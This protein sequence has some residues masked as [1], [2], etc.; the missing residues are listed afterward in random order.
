[1]LQNSTE[2]TIEDFTNPGDVHMEGARS[3]AVRF[4]G[5]GESSPPPAPHASSATTE[6][7]RKV[8]ASLA[9]SG[10][11]DLILLAS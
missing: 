1:M 8:G 7:T 6:S 10:C 2:L 9:L 4:W 5:N 3:L 11:C